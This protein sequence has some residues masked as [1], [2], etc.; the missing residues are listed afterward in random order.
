MDQRSAYFIQVLE[1]LGSPLILDSGLL[2]TPSDPD[3]ENMLA[4]AEAVAGLLNGCIKTSLQLAR[5]LNI[6]DD[7]GKADSIRLSLAAIT[8]PMLAQLY[9]SSNGQALNDKNI[10]KLTASLET[11][12][13]FSESFGV[14]EDKTQALSEVRAK[15]L[16]PN[17]ATLDAT[18]PVVNAV[19][20]Y[21]FGRS[22][23]KLFQ[24]VVNRLSPYIEGLQENL[25]FDPQGDQSRKTACLRIIA[26]LYEAAHMDE[27]NRILSLPQ[28][29]LE[30]LAG[31]DGKISMD[32]VW[33][34]F[35]T[36][37]ALMEVLIDSL[38]GAP[39]P[40]PKPQ[41]SQV[42]NPAPA[43]DGTFVPPAPAPD[44]QTEQTTQA[45]REENTPQIFQ[46]QPESPAK[47]SEPPKTD[48]AD[49]MSFFT[50]PQSEDDKG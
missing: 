50:Q 11:I 5:V 46:T 24:D 12:M 14:S 19:A 10:E 41:A 18:I 23:K 47:P 8:S 45:G 4:Q 43:P 1:K 33:R 21:S 29:E 2:S 6:H 40:Q 44:I 49:P 32:P 22:D 3:S 16:H 9:K 25:G 28:E 15:A 17:L 13:S 37:L 26:K 20:S 42:E 34:Q 36:R 7:E 35:E 39:V 31:D 48:P 30:T 27:T 38:L